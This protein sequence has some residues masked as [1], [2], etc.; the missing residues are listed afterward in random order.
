M[1]DPQNSGMAHIGAQ[2]RNARCKALTSKHQWID[3]RQAPILSGAAQRV[4][5]RADRCSRRDQLLIGPGFCPIRVGADRQVPI[6]SNRKPG[7]SASSRRGCEL[8]VGFLLQ[9][10]KELDAI[11]M[12]RRK[13]GNL[14][15]SWIAHRRR[16]AVP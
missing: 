15:R 7:L 10:L 6:E 14:R 1:I 2:R 13:G 12:R 11:A 4:G 8:P 3:R 9:K 5:W 16:P